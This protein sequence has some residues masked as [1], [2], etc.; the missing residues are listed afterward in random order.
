VP[1]TTA[2]QALL[3]LYVIDFIGG[4]LL[5]SGINKGD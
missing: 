4:W 3:Q 2:A 1:E 5:E